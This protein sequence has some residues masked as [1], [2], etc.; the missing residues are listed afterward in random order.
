MSRSTMG[1]S[2]RDWRE[3]TVVWLGFVQVAEVI[4]GPSSQSRVLRSWIGREGFAWT[5]VF[6]TLVLRCSWDCHQWIASSGIRARVLT[7]CEERDR[8]TWADSGSGVG[9][10][11]E[12]IAPIGVGAFPIG[13]ALYLGLSASRNSRGWFGVG[14]ESSSL[15]EDL[16]H[17][18]SWSM[19]HSQTCISEE[20]R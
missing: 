3:G 16:V 11:S 12:L 13:R 6:T 15:F 9:W 7:S 2:R 20:A 10:P 18:E 19:Q 1:R 4:Q 14:A 8:A 17:P 5:C